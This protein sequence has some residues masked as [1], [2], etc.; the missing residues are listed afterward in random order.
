MRVNLR[1]LK[2]YSPRIQAAVAG[3]LYSQLPPNAQLKRVRTTS[4]TPKLAGITPERD[5]LK[6][7]TEY[8]DMLM[9]C[10]RIVYVR[11]NPTRI[12]GSQGSI[13]FV[14]VPQSQ[15]G[16][17]DLLVFAKNEVFAIEVKASKG[18]QSAEQKKWMQAFGKLGYVYI[19]ARTLAE[20]T[21]LFPRV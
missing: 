6:D 7:V 2:E 21:D 5:V 13:R 1:D 15:L 20:V 12:T 17:P 9:A 8:L 18:K 14:K 19:V 10:G 11:H 16:A 3:T 4:P